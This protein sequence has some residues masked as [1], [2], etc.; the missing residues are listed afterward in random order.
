MKNIFIALLFCGFSISANCASSS[1]LVSSAISK[2]IRDF[3]L[4]QAEEFDFITF[5]S[6]TRISSKLIDDTIKATP[7]ILPYN[8][9]KV[10]EDEISC[11]IKQSAILIFDTFNGFID[12]HARVI[13]DNDFP[14]K[15]HFL[16]YIC[17]HGKTQA[18]S[19][20]LSTPPD[21]FHFESFLTHATD[22]HVLRLL[23]YE[24][25]QQPHCR[26][27]EEVEI[28][29]FSEASA[30]WKSKSFFLDKF[31]N[32]NGCELFVGIVYPQEPATSVEF[33]R[34]GT[35]R[36]VWGYASKFNEVIGHYLNYSINYNPLNAQ[37]QRLYNK[38]QRNDF[39]IY[40]QKQRMQS[41][42]IHS[43]LPFTVSE[44]IILLSRTKPST[45]IDKVSALFDI[46]I[47]MVAATVVAVGTT[48][49]SK[50]A[51]RKLRKLNE[52]AR[53]KPLMLRAL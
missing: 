21:I 6:D 10:S 25:F 12:F 26:Q 22:E 24:S 48:N 3:Y 42:V 41:K 53:M 39:S 2:I 38:T 51:Y 19:S 40:V 35:V 33:Y 11:K 20:I 36:K 7:D 16:V 14:R 28:N 31:K 23:S 43:S 34:N 47:G 46:L 8:V 1:K 44:D 30:N 27:W 4:S 18:I 15:F 49:A 13:L 5:G 50:F 37:T 52:E 45:F 29:Q 9:I 17:D 32:F